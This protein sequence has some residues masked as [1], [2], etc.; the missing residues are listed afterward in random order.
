MV[1]V[2]G[3]DRVRSLSA[4]SIFFIWD[5]SSGVVQPPFCE[6]HSEERRRTTEIRRVRSR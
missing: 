5:A 6:D 2:S 1:I 3:N 4:Q